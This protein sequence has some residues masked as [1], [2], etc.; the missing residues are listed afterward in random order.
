[1]VLDAA[2]GTGYGSK[3]LHDAGSIVTGVDIHQPAI[4]FAKEHYPGPYYLR[5][6]LS[7][8]EGEYDTIVS[9]ETLEHVDARQV[10]K[11]FRR[12]CKSLICSVPN[13]KFYPFSAERFARDEYPHLRHYLPDELDE[14]LSSSGFEVKSRHCQKTKTSDVEDG[15][16]GMFLVYVC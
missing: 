9:F 4:E 12:K 2:C 10:L 11:N 1:M 7:E 3:I 14:L 15:T 6:D 13:E 16:E 5:R 8:V